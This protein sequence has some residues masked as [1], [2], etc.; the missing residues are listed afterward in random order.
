ME[1]LSGQQ[2][3]ATHT[4]HGDFGGTSGRRNA[5]RDFDRK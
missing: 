4:S 5:L 3:T 1:S 2:L